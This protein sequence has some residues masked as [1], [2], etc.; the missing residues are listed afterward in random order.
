M[1]NNHSHTNAFPSF[2]DV[3][4]VR[5]LKKWFGEQCLGV[6]IVDCILKVYMHT[7]MYVCRLSLIN[8]TLHFNPKSIILTIINKRFLRMNKDF[9]ETGIKD[10]L[11]GFSRMYF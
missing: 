1:T 2:E 7:R 11:W 6:L 5:E 10:C 8:G 3:D 9:I 4:I